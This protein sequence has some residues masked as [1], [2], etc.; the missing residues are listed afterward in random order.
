MQVQEHP[1]FTDAP[2]E[3]LQRLIPHTAEISYAAGEQIFAEGSDS[4]GIYLILE[5]TVG[6]VKTLQS[7]TTHVISR[8][9][10][11]E[12]FGEL[13]VFTGDK[14]ALG[15]QAETA[16]RLG[17][18]PAQPLRDFIKHTPG[19]VDRIVNS[20]VGH[21]RHTT[22]HYVDNLVHQEKMALVGTMMNSIIHD[23]KNP[24]TLISLGAQM[25]KQQ[26]PDKKTVH[27]CNTIE[28]QVRRMVGM[29]NE[30]I[31]FSHGNQRV[32]YE[33][34]GLE[35]LFDRFRAL[36]EP[37]FE[38]DNVTLKIDVKPARFQAEGDKLIRVLQN[39]VGNAI[40]AFGKSK[41][42]V[43][44]SGRLNRNAILI[45]ITDNGPGIPEEIRE[46][47]FEPF[48]TYGKS[49]GTG[50]GTAIARSIVEA[51]KGKI[52]CE[53]RGGIGTTFRILLPKTPEDAIKDPM[54]DEAEGPATAD[55]QAE[56]TPRL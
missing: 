9:E 48:V 46:S 47:L 41:G 3:E 54:P 29:A 36:N 26:H 4:D 38:R 45:T 31:S 42:K 5:G 40:E 2:E 17:H 19:P 14:R 12:F 22:R 21:L 39:L 44:L 43:R 52:T 8:S 10:P 1:F 56:S 20:M 28:E 13:G 24:F 30:I 6:F 16:V 53:S 25:L 15:A 18:I 49:G 27:L 35:E 51:H 32:Q 37:F 50:L 23:F 11:G 55:S 7:N 33:D 34:L